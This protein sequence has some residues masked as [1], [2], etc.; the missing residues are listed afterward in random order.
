MKIF[1]ILSLLS[2]NIFSQEK[3]QNNDLRKGKSIFYLKLDGKS[4]S[5]LSQSATGDFRYNNK[6]KSLKMTSSEAQKLEEGFLDLFFE[7]KYSMETK[8]ES[9]CKSWYELY[10]RGD[11]HKVCVAQDKA[12]NLLKSKIKEIEKILI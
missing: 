11:D 6:S 8:S 5:E 7:L 1:I 3:T 9:S 12:V 2:F 4:I 10:L